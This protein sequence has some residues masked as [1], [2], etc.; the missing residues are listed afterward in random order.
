MAVGDIISPWYPMSDVKDI[1]H[2][3]KLGEE[4]GELST[5]ISRCLIQ[6]VDESE[7]VTGKPNKLWL[8]EEIADVEAGV[9][10]VKRRFNLN[11]EFIEDR[12]NRKMAGLIKW[13]HMEP[14]TNQ[15]ENT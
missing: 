5:V 2:L 15:G 11:R 7:P 8:E 9:E 12:K 10:L 3:G 4:T 13:H 6:G 14:F 1:K